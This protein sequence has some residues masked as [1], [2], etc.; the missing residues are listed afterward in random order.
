MSPYIKEKRKKNSFM[1]DNPN[2]TTPSLQNLGGFSPCF[3]LILSVAMDE[4]EARLISFLLKVFL[5]K[6]DAD[7]I[8]FI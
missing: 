5:L 7:R 6:M 4:T 3:I 8:I 1:C 2:F